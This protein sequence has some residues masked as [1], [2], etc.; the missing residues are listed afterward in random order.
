QNSAVSGNNTGVGNY[1]L[2]K[3]SW[4]QAMRMSG[5]YQ[6][7]WGINY[8]TSF[9]AQSGDYFFREVQIRDAL[10]TLLAIRIDPQAGRYEWTKVWDN[11][12]AKRFKTFGSQSIEGA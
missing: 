7:P 12:F 1:Q 5:T 3:S 4:N 9:S 6:F 2:N 8:A 11:R 10:N